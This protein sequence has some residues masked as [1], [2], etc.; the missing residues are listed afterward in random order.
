MTSVLLKRAGIAGE[1]RGVFRCDIEE[2]EIKEV[3][4]NT[5]SFPIYQGKEM[6]WSL[7]NIEELDYWSI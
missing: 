1:L 4:E 6:L 2:G 5:I 7:I 3:W